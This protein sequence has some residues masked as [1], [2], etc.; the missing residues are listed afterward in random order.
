MLVLSVRD[1]C[2]IR[3]RSMRDVAHRTTRVFL[4]ATRTQL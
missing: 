1:P 2:V 4:R 3:A